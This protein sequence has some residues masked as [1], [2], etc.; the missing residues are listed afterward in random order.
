MS[1]LNWLVLT[2]L[3]VSLIAALALPASRDWFW[4]QWRVIA[5][6]SPLD[7]LGLIISAA[8]LLGIT[9]LASSWQAIGKAKQYRDL[10]DQQAV[11]CRAE[12]AELGDALGEIRALKERELEDLALDAVSATA[13]VAKA[14]AL[15]R[16]KVRLP[17]ALRDLAG[18]NAH[19]GAPE[20]A[21]QLG[22]LAEAIERSV[23]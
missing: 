12:E 6:E 7:Q 16:L 3:A 19:L 13:P 23:S 10:A 14:R 8:G 11:A 4:T 9:T 18:L 15:D 20:R 22:D 1:R 21:R 5:E 17:L 2:G